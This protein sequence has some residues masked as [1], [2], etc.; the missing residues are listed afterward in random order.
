MDIVAFVLQIRKL[1]LKKSK[2]QQKNLAQVTYLLSGNEN[3]S[4]YHLV[5]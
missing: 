4:Y 3:L 5:S 2:Q 1:K